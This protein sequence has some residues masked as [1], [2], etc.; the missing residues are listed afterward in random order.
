MNRK[1]Y[2]SYNNTH[3][4]WFNSKS[5]GRTFPTSGELRVVKDTFKYFFLVDPDEDSKFSVL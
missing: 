1:N 5:G 4:N 3:F 2:T